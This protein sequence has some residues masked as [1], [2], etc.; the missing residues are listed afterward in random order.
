[1]LEVHALPKDAD[2][3][4]KSVVIVATGTDTRSCPSGDQNNLTRSCPSGDQK[5]LKSR[6]W[7]SIAHSTCY[8][9]FV[10]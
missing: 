6:H 10:P 2:E 1:V 4:M 9:R 7:E 3:G 5:S 8:G